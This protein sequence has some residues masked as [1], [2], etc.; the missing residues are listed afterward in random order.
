MNCFI[1]VET[2]LTNLQKPPKIRGFE[3]IG[4]NRRAKA[5]KPPTGGVGILLSSHFD[6]EWSESG[7]DWVATAV[8][9]N[10]KRLILVGVY[11]AHLL[12]G[13]NAKMYAEISNLIRSKCESTDC[14]LIG[15]DMNGHIPRFDGKSDMRGRLLQNFAEEN[16]LLILN[17]S[18]RCEG[19]YT[20][21]SAVIDYVLGSPGAVETVQHMY[22]D[23]KRLLS[24]ISDHNLI[25]VKCNIGGFKQ[26]HR[27]T[28]CL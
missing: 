21:K 26:K 16:D 1:A 17:G 28:F 6:V 11:V 3:W 2:H 8:R 22:I 9:C 23:D 14:I 19:R 12:R 25:T 4:S 27:E 5:G 10:K 13:A 24:S 15:G 7:E 20:R 18:E